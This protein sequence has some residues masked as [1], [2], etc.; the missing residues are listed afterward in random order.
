MYLRLQPHIQTSV[1]PRS[2]HKLCF[3]FFGPFEVLQRVGAVAYKLKLPAGS[4]VHPVFHVSQLKKAV[5]PTTPVSTDLSVLL[6]A[7]DKRQPEQILE[8]RLVR[9]GKKLL[10]QVKIL[11]TGLPESF[12]TWEQLHALHRRYAEAPAWGHAASRGGSIVTA[13]LKTEAQRLKKRAEQADSCTQGRHRGGWPMTP[14]SESSPLRKSPL[15]VVRACVAA[16]VWNVKCQI[17]CI[18][19]TF[20]LP[21]PQVFSRSDPDLGVTPGTLVSP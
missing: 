4:Q 16:G 1:A 12:A 11:W 19:P 14:S 6:I 17:G 10:P 2:S 7:D 21:L 3:R 18:S 9:Q 20:L 8:A 13:F 15:Q 5:A